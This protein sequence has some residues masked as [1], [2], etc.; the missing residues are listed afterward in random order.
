MPFKKGQ[1]GNPDGK[2]KGT[3]SKKT[4]TWEVFSQYCLT[5][6]LD[7]FKKELDSL[8]GKD[9]VNSYLSLLEYHKPKLS[10]GTTQNFNIDL[11]KLTKPQLEKIANAKSEIE[12]AQILAEEKITN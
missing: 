2:A 11:D 12:L 4:E 9:Y 8:T 5:G 1:S 7:K 6:G 3:K 10:R